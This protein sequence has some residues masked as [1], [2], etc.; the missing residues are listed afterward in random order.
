MPVRDGVYPLASSNALNSCVPYRMLDRK[1]AKVTNHRSEAV[2]FSAQS[3]DRTSFMVL[4]FLSIRP[5]LLC[6]LA[7]RGWG[8]I[9]FL[10]SI[11]RKTALLNSGSK[12]TATGRP[13]LCIH[14]D[15]KMA[16]AAC[17]SRLSTGSASE[18]E[19]L[20]RVAWRHNTVCLGH[21]CQYRKSTPTE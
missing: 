20:R 12:P 19:V 15:S 2:G 21:R 14:M 8:T 9:P 10:L 4:C 7:G 1:I 17:M 3:L 13:W 11:E 6:L 5:I 16:A 18:N